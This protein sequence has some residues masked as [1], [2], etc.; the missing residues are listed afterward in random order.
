LNSS[1][2][3]EDQ[4][5]T[6][7]P[8]GCSL[9]VWREAVSEVLGE[10]AEGVVR[11]C[12]LGAETRLEGGGARCGENGQRLHRSNL[13]PGTLRAGALRAPDGRD[14]ERQ[15]TKLGEVCTSAAPK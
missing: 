14:Y 8:V 15:E 1:A 9:R 4:P 7:L 10:P 13:L 12:L 11:R 2:V 5:T 6:V 3:I